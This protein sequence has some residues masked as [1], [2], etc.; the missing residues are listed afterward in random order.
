MPR[1]C[2]LAFDDIEHIRKSDFLKR[3]CTLYGERLDE[4]CRVLA[5]TTGC[6]G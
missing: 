1:A 2:V 6:R 3:I 5:V 4:A